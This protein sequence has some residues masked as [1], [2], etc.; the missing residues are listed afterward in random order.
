MA[1]KGISKSATWILMGLLVLGL[2]GFGVTNLSGTVRSVGTVGDAEIDVTTYARA[3]QNELRALSAARGE[4]V[5][6]AEAR[7]EGID[8]QVLG[9]LVARAALEDEAARMGIS[10]GDETLREQIVAIPGFQGLDGSFDREA[11]R[12]ALQ[13]AGMSEA[14]FEEAIRAETASSLVQAAALSGLRVPDAYMDAMLTYL[15]ERRSVSF[16]VLDRSALQTGLPV[17]DEDELRAYHQSHLPDFTTPETRRITYAWVTPTMILDTVEVDEAAL[18]EAYSARAEDFNLPERRL[19]E[20]L[21]YSDAEEA[22]AAKARTEQ[23]IAFEMLVSERG[24][25]LSDVDLGD[26]TAADLGGAAAPVFAAEAGDIVGPVETDLGPALFRVNAVLAA[27]STPFEEAEPLLRDELAAD[28]ARR[29]IEAM[30]DRVDDML[31]GGATL[32]DI[33]KE[34]ELELGTIDWHPGQAE[35]IAGYDAFR[36]AAAVA[37][38]NDFPEVVALEDGGIFALRL[39]GVE[40]PRIQPLED[41]RDAVEEGWR[42][43]ATVAALR[44]QAAPQVEQLR[45]GAAFADLGLEPTVIA[46]MT[47]R[48]YQPDAPPAF[49]ETVF[50]MSPGEVTVIDGA[51]RIFVLRLDAVKPPAGADD[52]LERLRGALQ[53]QVAADLG[54][55]M[56]QLL[57]DDIRNRAGVRL[58]QAA[59]NAVHANFN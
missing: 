41:V 42:A 25:E 5:T 2:G 8:G 27:Q 40:E 47:R 4:P 56:F 50:G 22:A 15:A 12:F 16:A 1:A 44:A 31:A 11:Y 13:Q 20:R 59:L 6:F 48:D 38:E 10:V 24:L 7:A 3:L 52:D 43:S 26:V 29:A 34:T 57:A 9:R 37:D 21:V 53:E 51:A 19:L 39:D 28:R 18:R 55:D 36:S 33:A 23:G 14:A 35:G 17:P 58:D 45:S 49:I 30:I 54:Q 32:E 46:D